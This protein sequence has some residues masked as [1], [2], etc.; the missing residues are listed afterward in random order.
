MSPELIIPG[1][2]RNEEGTSISCPGIVFLCIY[3]D[4]DAMVSFL[5]QLFTLVRKDVLLEWRQKYAFYGILLY[6]VSTVFVIYVTLNQ[7]PEKTWD[8]L[9]WILQ[10][11]IT[12]N[13]VAKSFLQEG[14]GRMLYF[15]SIAGATEFI[16]SKLLYNVVLM[17][18]MSGISLVLYSVL[19]GNPLI[20]VGFFVEIACL[21][22][23]SLALVF[24]MLAAISAKANQNAALMAIM[25]FP[26]VIPILMILVNLSK[27]A[28][29]P[30]YQPGLGKMVLLL[31]GMDILVIALSLVLFP[32]LWKN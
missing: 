18:V 31:C 30:V 19:L 8:A 10:L 15:Y 1:M 29:L 13:T 9:F 12:V 26:L 23:V 32:F 27:T 3:P 24:T 17:L 28:F 4:P 2:K 7:P 22:G 14:Q 25:G 11:F 16:L 21:G 6:V 20:K 5:R